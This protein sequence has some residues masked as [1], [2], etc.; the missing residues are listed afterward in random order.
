MCDIDS[1]SRG[2]P[3]HI[4]KKFGLQ[5]KDCTIKGF[6]GWD[7]EPLLN[8]LALECYQLFPEV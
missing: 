1:M 3:W 4:Q 6:D 5:N 7:L 8:G 2:I